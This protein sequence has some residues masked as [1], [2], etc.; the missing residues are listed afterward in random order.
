MAKYFNLFPKTYYV[1]NNDI[2]SVLTNLTTR[3]NFEK[4]FKENTSVF[5]KY[6]IKYSDTPEG[7][8][9][10]LYGSSERH[11][12]VLML[13]DI[14]NP[15]YDWPLDQRSLIRFI[16]SKYSVNAD[17]ANGQSGL[18]WSQANIKEYYK[19]VTKTDLRTNTVVVEKFETD[20][21]TY[22]NTATSITNVTLEDATPSTITISKETKSYYD[23]EVETNDTKRTI[24][25]LK[26]EF[27]PAVEDEFRRVIK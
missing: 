2:L 6:E 9:Y 27:V 3:F 8:A 5:Y 17:T 20:A 15:Q 26:P 13:N 4:T 22:T 24:K 18:E 21:N 25:L 12:M 11:W 7:I 14:V 10:K 1:G 19:I 16:E 23:Y